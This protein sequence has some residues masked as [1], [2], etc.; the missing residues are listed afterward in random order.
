MSAA[1]TLAL[2]TA[3]TLGG[4]VLAY[5]VD[6]DAVVGVDFN[7][8][9]CD[10]SSG[11]FQYSGGPRWPLIAARVQMISEYYGCTSGITVDDDTLALDLIDSVGP[12]GN[13]LQQEHTLAHFREE[14]FLSD[15]CRCQPW[16]SD[17]A[18]GALSLEERAAEMAGELMVRPVECP[19]SAEQCRQLDA[20]VQEGVAKSAAG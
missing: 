15:L 19:L 6:P 3:E 2:G 7:P 12:G 10:M 5:S 11:L 9:Y 13:F 17:W 8:S 16:E 4:L 18:A 14:L 1:G 20:I